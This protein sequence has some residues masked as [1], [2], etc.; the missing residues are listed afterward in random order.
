MLRGYVSPTSPP[1]HTASSSFTKVNYIRST[2]PTFASFISMFNDA[3]ITAGKSPLGFLN[4]WLYEDGYMALNDITE[5][6]NLGCGTQG[7]K[8][9]LDG[10]LVGDL[11][12]CR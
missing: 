7:F 6:N 12:G 5:G 1:R 2:S 10:I 9:L 8:L 3:G 11:S 4:Q